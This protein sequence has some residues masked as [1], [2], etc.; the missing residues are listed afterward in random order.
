MRRPNLCNNS[1]GVADDAYKPTNNTATQKDEGRLS[2]VRRV[3]GGSRKKDDNCSTARIKLFGVPLVD[4]PLNNNSVPKVLQRLCVFIEVHGMK[5]EGLFRL[6]GGNTTLIDSLKNQFNTEGDAELEV[7]NDIASVALLLVVWLKELPQPLLSQ[8]ITTELVSLMHKYEGDTWWGPVCHESILT[9]GTLPANALD[10]ILHLLHNYS[11][12][13]PTSMTYLPSVFSP[14]LTCAEIK[15]LAGPEV[16]QLTSKLIQDYGVIFHKRNFDLDAINKQGA[17]FISDSVSNHKQRKRKEKRDTCLKLDRKFVRSNSEERPALN[18]ACATTRAETMRRVSSHEDF[19]KTHNNNKIE[20][21]QLKKMALPLHE[22]NSCSPQRQHT[23]D[24]VGYASDL[25]DENEHERRRNSER[26]APQHPRTNGGRRRRTKHHHSVQAKENKSFEKRKVPTVQKGDI[27]ALTPT[28]CQAESSPNAQFELPSGPPQE[29][30]K[31][32]DEDLEEDRSPSPISG[33]GSPTLDLN[34]L[35]GPISG[36]EPVPSIPWVPPCEERLI[37]P[38]NSLV[39]SRRTYTGGRASFEDEPSVLDLATQINN[40][41]RKLKKYDEGFEREFG[42]KP[43]HADKMANPDT[44]KMCATLNKLRKQL[45]NTKEECMKASASA[46][47]KKSLKEEVIQEIEKRLSEKRIASGRSESLDN[48]SHNELVEEKV[49]M[50]KALLQLEASFGR[51]TSKEER[52]MVRDLYDRYR[53]IKRMILRLAPSKMKDSVSELGTILEHETMD[54]ASSPPPSSSPP[55]AYSPNVNRTNPVDTEVAAA[56]CKTPELVLDN[57]HSLPPE[58]LFEMQ[59]TTREEKKRLRRSLREFEQEYQA[60]TGRRLQKE[61]RYP[62]ESTYLDYKQAKAKL[63]FI[64]AL[65]TK[66]K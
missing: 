40:F 26:F 45:K 43:S 24:S 54:F 37:S 10:T 65:I 33:V 41:K 47:E 27:L 29:Q 7:C 4:L 12:K 31:E 60:K 14:L 66:M 44:K 21:N 39:I 23:Q 51:P 55:R 5:V 28:K 42:Y 38:R 50:Q 3:L 19:S 22:R 46:P 18:T 34:V 17:V 20:P 25:Y 2:I 52:D 13:Q 63:R 61:D 56:R 16:V 62:N 59:R 57:L 6:S 1:I 48:M 53:T 64:D 9:A 30:I 58:E 11:A 15:D 8:E 32:E 49:A 35:Q 36:S